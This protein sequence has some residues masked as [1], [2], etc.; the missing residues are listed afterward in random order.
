MKNL[1]ATLLQRLLGPMLALALLGL[2]VWNTIF[3]YVL[4]RSSQP[5]EPQR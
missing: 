5:V 4:A 3:G 1:L 2:V